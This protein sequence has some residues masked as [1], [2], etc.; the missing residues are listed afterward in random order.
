MTTPDAKHKLMCPITEG[1]L[2]RWQLETMTELG[3]FIKK[4]APGKPGALRAMI[5]SLIF[6]SESP[7]SRWIRAGAS[8]CTIARSP[9]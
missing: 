7:N 2:W 1:D 3:K 5:Q 6:R 4:H 9:A 8:A